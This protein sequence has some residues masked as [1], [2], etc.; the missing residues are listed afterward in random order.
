MLSTVKFNQAAVDDSGPLRILIVED[1]PVM[2]LGLCELFEEYS[3]FEI[4]AQVGDGYAA[5]DRTLH[6]KPDLVIMDIGLPKL[7]GIQQNIK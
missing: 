5:V 1:D 4:I 6:L 3:Q 7:D 2:Q